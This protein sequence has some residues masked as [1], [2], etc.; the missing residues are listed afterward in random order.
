VA[1]HFDHGLV[2]FGKR[3]GHAVERTVELRLQRGLAEV[4]GHA[5]GQAQHDVVA[6]ALHVDAGIGSTLA[7][8]P[9]LLVLIRTHAGAGQC[10]DTCTHHRVL[11]TLGRAVTGQ[12]AGGHADGGTDQRIA[13]G[14]ALLLGR[15]A[16]LVTLHVGATGGAGRQGGSGHQ[17]QGHV[18]GCGSNHGVLLGCRLTACGR[19]K[20]KH[21]DAMPA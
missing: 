2:V 19:Q 15:V 12:Q 11:A 3:R 13:A 9:F 21:A 14:A 8:L 1:D 4:E 5:I 6:L 10:T 16:V 18:A 7:Q 20:D 17:G